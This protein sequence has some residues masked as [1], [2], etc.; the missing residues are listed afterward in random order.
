M[1]SEKK[2]ARTLYYYWR[3]ILYSWQYFLTDISTASVFWLSF[4][5]IGL[6]LRAFFNYLTGSEDFGLPVG[7]IIG[8]HIGYAVVASLALIGAILANVAFRQKSTALMMRNMLSR[9]LDLPGGQPLPVKDDGKVMSPGE[10]VS[11]FRD[12]T[13]EM[14]WAVTALEDTIGLGVAAAISVKDGV[15]CAT[16]NINRVQRALQRQGVRIS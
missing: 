6:I 11:T 5:V 12:D 13:N 3:L 9:I 8:L 1:K 15:D 14:V 7:P 16:V 2:P 4:T 10:V